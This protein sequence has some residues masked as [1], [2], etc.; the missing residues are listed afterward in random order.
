MVLGVLSSLAVR[1]SGRWLVYFN[2]AVAVCVLSLFLTVPW[3]DLL[4]VMVAFPGHT[5]PL[6]LLLFNLIIDAPQ[7]ISEILHENKTYSSKPL[8][9]Y[10]Y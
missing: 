7:T 3:V 8:D 10:K 5:H 9:Q 2:C 6:T 1:G 4:S